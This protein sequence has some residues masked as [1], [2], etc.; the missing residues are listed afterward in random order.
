MDTAYVRLMGVGKP[1]PKTAENKVQHLHFRYLKLLVMDG[2]VFM[3][4]SGLKVDVT[5]IP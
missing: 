3:S 2:E 5:Y 1:T 4:A